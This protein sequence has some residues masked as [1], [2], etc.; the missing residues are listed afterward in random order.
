FIE[1]RIPASIQTRLGFAHKSSGFAGAFAAGLAAGIVASPCVGPVL[2]SILTY[3][4][5][6]KSLFF[7]FIYLFVFALGIGFPFLILGTFSHLITRLPK[8]GPWMEFVKFVF[9]T[10]MI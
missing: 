9:G 8:A 10:V 6:T 4:A 5:Q 2:I 3:I 1:I 7:G